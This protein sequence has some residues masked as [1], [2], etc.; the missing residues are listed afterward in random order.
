[1]NIY[2][3]KEVGDHD[4][5]QFIAARMREVFVIEISLEDA[6][7]RFCAKEKLMYYGI[8]GN[9]IAV[10]DSFNKMRRWRITA[11]QSVGPCVLG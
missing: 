9:L 10:S 7:K 6:I 3:F 4:P 11:L 8:N 2:S 5:Q 1:M